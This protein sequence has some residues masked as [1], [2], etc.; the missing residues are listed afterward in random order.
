M[1]VTVTYTAP[2][3]TNYG[4]TSCK[5][6]Y[7][8]PLPDYS[9]PIDEASGPKYRKIA[10]NGLPLSDE[11]PQHAAESDQEK[12]ETFVDALTLGLR[13]STTD[14]YLPVSGSD[15]A[16]S[17]RRDTRSEVWNLRDGLRPHEQPDHPF[18]ICWSSNLAPNVHIAK[19][20]N[21][22]QTEPDK[23][24]VTDETGAVHTFFIWYDDHGH[25]S[26]HFFPM[27]TAKNEQTPNLESLTQNPTYPVSYT[28][29]R[30]Y[31]STLTYV[32]TPLNLKID[33]DRLVGSQYQISNTYARLVQATDRL[34]NT[35]YY[36]FYGA[37]NLVPATIT[38]NNQPNT[39]ISIRQN[40]GVITDIW[41][42][43]G[44]HTSFGYTPYNDGKGAAYQLTSV[45]TPDGATTYSY[46]TVDETDATPHVATDPV[47]IYTH[48]ELASITDPRGNTYQFHY[49]ID[50]TKLNYMDTPGVFTGYYPQSGLP[51][52]V[53]QITMPDGTSSNF[54]NNSKIWVEYENGQPQ[55]RGQRNIQVTDAAGSGRVY[56]FE[57]AKVIPLPKFKQFYNATSFTDAKVV[58]YQTMSIDFASAV[59]YLGAETYNFDI[60]AAMAVSSIRDLSGNITTFAHTE[61]WQAPADYRNIM[62]D[63]TLNGCYG[64]PTSQTDAMGHTKSFTYTPDTRIMTSIT[65]ENGRLTLY[66]VDNLGRRTMETI[67]SSGVGTQGRVT[68]FD[69]GYSNYPGFTSQTI[70]KAISGS[71]DPSWVKD[72]VTQFVPD[73]NGRVAYQIVDPSGLHL[74]TT[75]T[76][77]ANGNKLTSTD[78]KGNTTWFSYDSRNRLVAVTYADGTHK[79]MA[80]DACGNKTAEYDEN[81]LATLYEYDTLNRLVTQARDMNGNGAI[82]NLDQITRYAYDAVGSKV[83]VTDP[84]GNS[85]HMAYDWL[86]RLISTIEPQTPDGLYPTTLL[87]YGANSGGNAFDSS[88]FK[89]THIIDPRG[90]VTDVVYDAL[91]RPVSKTVGTMQGSTEVVVSTTATQYD[92]VGNAILTTDPLGHQTTVRYDALNR[93]VLTVNADGTWD[94]TLYTSTGLK[95][96]V[97]DELWD[98]NKPNFHATDT[99][100]DGAGRPIIVRGSQVDGNVGSPRP[101]TTT[102][103]DAAGNVAATIN[104][105]GKEWDYSYD[106]RNRKVQEFQ[107]AVLD[108]ANS[109]T[110]TRPVITKNY[111]AAG[112]VI[113]VIDARGFETDTVYDAANRVT[114]VNAPSV[115][116]QSGTA[117]PLDNGN[118]R[119]NTHTTYDLN[120][121]VLTVRDPNGH[122]TTN[123]YDSHNRLIKT[124]DALGIDVSYAYDSVG[125][126]IQVTDGLNHS[127]S[128]AYDALNRNT[129][130]TDAAGH[131]T[132]FLYDGLNK[133]QRIDALNRTT[134]YLYDI[135][136]RLK[137]VS[138]ASTNAIN[139]VRNYSYDAVGNLLTVVEPGK[140][141]IADVAYTYDGLNR[142]VS[143]TSGGLMHTYQYDLAG[144]RLQTVYGGTGRTITSVYDALNRL[145]TMTENAH[146]TTY[147]YDLAGNVTQKTLPNGDTETASFDALNRT[148]TQVVVNVG[149]AHLYQYD[150]GHDKAGNVTSV[151]E[152]YPASSLNNRVVT[153]IYD[154]I[155]RLVTESVSGTSPVSTTYGYDNANNRLSKAVT[156]GTD[157]GT[158]NYFY[159]SINQLLNYN[160]GNRFVVLTYDAAGN[161]STRSVTVGASYATDNYGYDFENRLTSLVRYTSPGTGTYTYAYDYRTR[162]ILRNETQAGGVSTKVVFSGGLSVQEYAGGSTTTSV[163]YL[164]GSD[165]GGGVG[166]I[167]YTI[168][169]TDLSYTHENR[170]GD[171]VA[172]TS[173]TGGV[174]YQAAYEAYGTRT[175]EH[176]TTLDRQ[177]ANTKDEDPTGLLNEGFRYRDLETGSFITRDPL[178]FVDGPNVYTY[179]KQNPWTNFDPE[180]LESDKDGVK[181]TRDGHHVSPVETWKDNDALSPEVRE[182]LDSHRVK[183]PQ[184]VEAPSHGNSKA[185]IKYTE[186]VSELQQG[187]IDDAIKRGVDPSSLSGR[188]A[189]EFADGMVEHVMKDEYVAKFNSI[190][191]QGEGST[192]NLNQLLK[193]FN[194]VGGESG[195]S[196]SYK[197]AANWLGRGSKKLPIVGAIITTAGVVIGVATAETKQQRNEA[198]INGAFDAT[199][200]G[201][202]IDASGMRDLS[203]TLDH[204][205]EFRDNPDYYYNDKSAIGNHLNIIKQLGSE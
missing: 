107:P 109:N 99:E 132:Q 61:A 39:R 20:N 190:I 56:R 78:P 202:V 102:Y 181:I 151:A 171:V 101:V 51:M 45:T 155:N 133:T 119:P 2:D 72:L 25:N 179:V 111:D 28:F 48:A 52:N 113:A 118:A 30:K 5:F 9:L 142:Q 196:K 150:Y 29:Q 195:W 53:T 68:A 183:A 185:H 177:K 55:Q 27:P 165:Y 143:E 91:Y 122:I 144:N 114:D 194:K 18:G 90:V 156:G 60:N 57:N 13:H 162:R 158:T 173:A 35:I 33:E 24:Y 69:Y 19:S 141:G 204:A 188:A 88:S 12:E 164:R 79:V 66:A 120:G 95:W 174:T 63:T 3:G 176:L 26:P 80:Y 121:N 74:V 193:I 87:S 7:D 64:D 201:L 4:S 104:P 59:G 147:G 123:F 62:T 41:D 161:R 16:L 128:F 75:Y 37:T 93:P 180:G 192:E 189:K 10:M 31:G 85:T 49:G 175:Q 46:S 167:L 81:G 163:E 184:G 172:K 135:R 82:D 112:R 71:G 203:K 23:A 152:T 54:A 103:Y 140:S 197:T 137:T 47:K 187:F 159:N 131:I 170:R 205:K 198:F 124:T 100:Y 22:N 145:S 96:R 186:K 160:D 92:N 58:C 86:H 42:A 126:R 191:A 73:I 200:A 154:N 105:L 6:V 139:S 130:I 115:P 14:V 76:Y 77:D 70:V 8:P 36:Q 127:T 182:R 166:G 149:N 108:A 98:F 34:G 89:P 157:A 43:N 199:P 125:N 84:N 32:L 83:S 136:N 153:N 17:A 97:Q 106:A 1:V 146:V 40:N 110:L 117:A 15:F 94:S 44:N 116:Y 67:A 168:R 50:H 65:D 148:V 178:G 11:K 21:P 138:Y 169:G 129:Q 134:S 38:V